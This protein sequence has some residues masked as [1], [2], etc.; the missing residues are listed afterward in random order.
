MSG[1][2][3]KEMY[4]GVQQ[5]HL[6]CD[7]NSVV[8]NVHSLTQF[9]TER[10]LAADVDAMREALQEG[11]LTSFEHVPGRFN[12]TDGLTKKGH[13]LKASI[14]RAKQG[15]VFLPKD[16]CLVTKRVRPLPVEFW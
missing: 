11:V 6:R 4:G 7:A 1:F 12:I 10:R 3:I 5:T 8:K 14:I 15:E 13:N 16:D 2:N 9:P